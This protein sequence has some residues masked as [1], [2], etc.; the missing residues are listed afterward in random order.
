MGPRLFSRMSWKS[1]EGD[2]TL[3]GIQSVL[4]LAAVIMRVQP[5]RLQGLN[6]TVYIWTI[7]WRVVE[8]PTWKVWPWPPPHAVSS[9][10]GYQYYGFMHPSIP[11]TGEGDSSPIAIERGL[12]TLHF[13]SRRGGGYFCCHDSFM[14]P[15]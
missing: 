12:C 13:K 3:P 15:V 2:Y 10:E 11:Q 8:P 5:V 14:L 4:F 7:V 1:K 9:S 6:T